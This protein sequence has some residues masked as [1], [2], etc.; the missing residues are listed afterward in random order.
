MG[1]SGITEN[2]LWRFA[3]RFTAQIVSFF[4][5][6]VLARI[7][8][9]DDYGTVALV[10]IY[11]EI[12]NAFVS[13]GLGNALIQK[14]DADAIDFS[15]VLYFNLALSLLIYVVLF[16][17][18]PYVSRFYSNNLLSSILRVLGIRLILASINTIQQAY[19]SKRMEFKKFFL[20][21]LGG[22]VVSGI[23]GL[24]LALNGFGV[25]ALVAQYITNTT[26]DTIVLAFSIKWKPV[27]AFS[28]KR[29]KSLFSYGWKILFEGVANTISSQI[30]NILIGK[31]YSDSDLG[32]YTRAQQFPQLIMTNINTSIGSVLFPAMS[33]VQDEEGHVVHIMR[34]AVRISSFILFPMLL[35]LAATADNL[36]IVLLTEKWV[37]CIPYL[38]VFCFIHLLSIGMQPRHQALKAMGR[39]DVFMIEH[40]FSRII[41]FTVLISVYRISVMAI[42]LSSIVGTLILLAIIMFTSKKYTGYRYAD[43]IKDVLDVSLIS[44]FMFL[45]VFFIGKVLHCSPIIELIIQVST[46]VFL[47]WGLSYLVKPDGYIFVFNYVYSKI[48]RKKN[49][50]KTD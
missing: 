11:I 49:S 44:S 21:T 2:L 4:I 7:L 40:F 12:A 3:E 1:Q 14:K 10:L 41:S 8:S 24:V 9:P 38:Y 28:W 26:V 47:Y 6:I 43:Q 34:R 36:I 46:G 27:L 33:N 37:G 5:S 19:V 42:A 35:G 18:A 29:I 30:Q 48:M 23:V 32:F 22:T 45:V 50:D 25:W 13:Y 39:S 31:V 17:S 16:L 20:S 15:S